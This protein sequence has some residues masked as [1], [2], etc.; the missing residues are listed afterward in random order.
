MT[1][2]PSR[3]LLL[4][5]AKIENLPTT[6]YS[7]EDSPTVE[8]LYRTTRYE[9]LFDVG[10]AL[11]LL[12][13]GSDLEHAFMDRWQHDAGV[14]I[15]S[16]APLQTLT[17]HLRSLVHARVTGDVAVLFR[18]YDPRVMRHWLPAMRADEKDHMM[19]PINRVRLPARTDQ[20]EQWIA[21]EQDRQSAQPYGERPW[22]YLDEQQLQQLNQG[23]LELFDETLLEH[24]RTYFPECLAAKTLAEQR[25]WAASCREGAARYGYSTP[26]EVARWAALVATHGTAFPQA[27][28]HQIY[29][30]ILQH[31]TLNATQRMDALL[32]E[33]HRHLLR[34][35]KESF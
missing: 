12:R 11:V 2:T 18:Y 13:A 24:V 14:M 21:R 33:L 5:G 8:W 7:L 23:K 29:R 1:L 17:A 15:E 22:L 28:E 32:V 19:G 3:Y 10:P 30:D 31:P 16:D 20:G 35:D 9:A 27:P 25:E 4:D 34:T 26:S 6:V